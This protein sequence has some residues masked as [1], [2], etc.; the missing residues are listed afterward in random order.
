MRVL[1]G[2]RAQSLSGV[3]ESRHVDHAEDVTPV[4]LGA[5]R[6]QAQA[7]RSAVFHHLRFAAGTERETLAA[8]GNA[9]RERERPAA[10]A[11]A[12]LD[13]ADWLSGADAR[14]GRPWRVRSP[15]AAAACSR[16]GE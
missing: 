12:P 14:G 6:W 10:D 1:S 8:V 15:A 3:G 2:G 5:S 11:D 4:M 9:G 7:F 16:V 13:L